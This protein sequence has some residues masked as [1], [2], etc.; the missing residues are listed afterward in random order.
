MAFTQK[1]LAAD[2]TY[3]QGN[4]GSGGNS[5]SAPS[6]L[7]MSA[8][9][10]TPGGTDAGNLT[11]AIF[12][13]TLSEMN[14]LTVLPFAST[15]VGQNTVVLRAG[16]APDP[17]G[18]VFEGTVTLAYVDAKSQPDVCF[19]VEAIG[20]HVEKIKP[21]QPISVQGSADVATVMG[22]L[23]KQIGRSFENNGVSQKVQNLYLPGSARQQIEALARLAGVEWAIEKDTLAI[24]P[25]GQARQGDALTISPETGL[26]SYPA[27]TS[28]GIVVTTEYKTPVKRGAKI[29]VKSSLQQA[30]GPWSVFYIEYALDSYTPHGSWFATMQASKISAQD[31]E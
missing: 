10:T 17:Q 14:R 22:S 8:R 26:V 2:F 6:G 31:S 24:W 18:V 11:L 16:D 5:Y 13:M 1:A 27:F 4:F 7:R 15:A 12:G 21:A 25:P 29:N 9:I 30:C 23:A 28:S 3:A 19:R 20:A